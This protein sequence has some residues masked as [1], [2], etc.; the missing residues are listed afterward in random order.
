MMAVPPLTAK[1]AVVGQ[2]RRPADSHLHP[3]V[4]GRLRRVHSALPAVRDRYQHGG[5]PRTGPVQP[6]G[7][8]R[9]HLGSGE[10]S[11]ELV[12]CYQYATNV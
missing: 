1:A 11:L 4:P 8:G 3:A 5:Q 12:R 2:A 6:R 7:H 10:R 9:G